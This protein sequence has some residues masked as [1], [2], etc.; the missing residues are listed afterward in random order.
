ML[1]LGDLLARLVP[2]ISPGAR[3]PDDVARLTYTSGSTGQPKACAHSYRAISLAYSPTD[4][5]RP[6][7][8]C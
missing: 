3:R 7:P 5:R 1:P 8:A 6:W 4:G 2:G